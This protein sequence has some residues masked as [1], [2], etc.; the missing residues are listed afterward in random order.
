MKVPDCQDPLFP[1]SL[2]RLRTQGID[3]VRFAFKHP[4]RFHLMF[5]RDLLLPDDD[6][7]RAQGEAAPLSL[8]VLT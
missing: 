2:A 8:R 4:G 7:L 1:H 3:P 6:W 5:G